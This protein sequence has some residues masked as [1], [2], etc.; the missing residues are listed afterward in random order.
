MIMPT[1]VDL[2]GFV[3][4]KKFIVKEVAVLRR[5]TVITHYIFSC[6]MPWNLLLHFTVPDED[7]MDIVNEAFED[8]NF[9]AIL[10]EDDKDVSALSEDSDYNGDQGEENEESEDTKSKIMC[11]AE[12]MALNEETKLCDIFLL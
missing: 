6:P 8:V 2:Q 12:I 9:E 11:P 7:F 1:F 5:G 3:V 10:D 4:D